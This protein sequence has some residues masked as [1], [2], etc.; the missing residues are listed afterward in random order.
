MRLCRTPALLGVAWNRSLDLLLKSAGDAR[1]AQHRGHN[2]TGAACG[3]CF[4]AGVGMPLGAPT[5]VLTAQP[6]HN[7]VASTLRA[8]DE[9]LS[10]HRIALCVMWCCI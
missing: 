7:Y 9:L 2:G 6:H 5:S 4:S 8:E 3:R 10:V 1:E